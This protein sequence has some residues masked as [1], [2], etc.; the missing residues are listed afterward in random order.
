MKTNHSRKQ[1][2]T[3]NISKITGQNKQKVKQ[4]KNPYSNEALKPKHV[5]Y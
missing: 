1:K 2:I 3:G 4:K 5:Q